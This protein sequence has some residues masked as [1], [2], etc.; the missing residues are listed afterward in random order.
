MRPW[1]IRYTYPTQDLPQHVMSRDPT[2]QLGC[3]IPPL[4]ATHISRWCLGA[5]RLH[6]LIRSTYQRLHMGT[7]GRIALH[8]TCRTPNVHSVQQPISPKIHA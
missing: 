8:C 2:V 6:R 5:L 4:V 7:E 1:R 3:P